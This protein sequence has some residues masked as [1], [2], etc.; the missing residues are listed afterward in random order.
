MTSVKGDT[1]R[2]GRP[3]SEDARQAILEATREQL[4]ERGYDQLSIQEVSEAAGVGKQTVYRWW[5]TRAAL[6]AD[7]VLEGGVLSLL[8]GPPDTGDA[9]KDLQTW[10][11]ILV[12]RSHNPQE[13]SLFRGL[14]AAA[15]ESE[16][17]SRKLFEQFTAP[18]RALLVERMT[19]AQRT[20]QVRSDTPLLL[21]ADALVGLLLFRILSRQ[22]FAAEEMERL[23]DLFF[24][25]VRKEK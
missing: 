3:R 4:V 10:V 25:G 14:T 8:N 7:C 21:I 5:P 19:T 11:R 9:R 2:R 24:V 22:P 13:A 6:V 17:A 15:A 12:E 20:G 18:R 16:E 23:V 1:G